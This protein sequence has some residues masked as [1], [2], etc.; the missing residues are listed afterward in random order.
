MLKQ[1]VRTSLSD[2]IKTTM[3][4]QFVIPVYQR[5]YTWSPE[6]ETARYMNDIEGLLKNQNTNRFL[7][8]IIYMESE[9]SAMFRQLQIVDGQQR[10]TTSF[11]FLLALKKYAEEQKDINTAGM[12]GDY[13]LYNRH[14]QGQASLR[15]KPAVSADDV[16][17][18]LVYGNEKDLTPKEKETSVYRNYIY[19]YKRIVSFAKNHTLLE[20]LDTLSRMDILEFPLSATDNAQQIFESINSAGAPLTSADLIRNYVL[21]NHPDAEQERLYRMYWQPMEEMYPESRKLEEFF[22][23]YLAARTYDLLN[24][25]DVY[26]GFKKYWNSNSNSDENKL[27][28]VNRY[29]RYYHDIY[30]GPCSDAEVEKALSDFRLS[31]SRLPAPFFM[32][33]MHLRDE[34]EITSEEL[35]SLIRL[36]DSYLMRRALSGNDSSS[37]SRYFPTLLRSVLTSWYKN[38]KD[39]TGITRLYLITYN[40][41]R[42]L[43][44]PTD[45]QLKTQLR[46]INAYSLTCIR[47]VLERIEH[48]HAT[49]R[50]D[51]SDLNIEHIMPQHPDTWW[52]KHSGAKD[53]DEYTAYAN[54]IGNLTLCAE[55]DNTRMGNEDFAYKKKVLSQT[56]HIRMNTEILKKKTWNIHEILKRCDEMADE[57]IQ[58]YPYYGNEEAENE[59]IEEETSGEE[60]YTLNSPTVSARA[61]VHSEKDTEVLAGSTMKE[62]GN[63]EMKKM[64]DL[65]RQM[66]EQGYFHEIEGGRVQF[67]QSRHFDSL[68]TAAQFLMHRGGENLSRWKKEGLSDNWSTEKKKTD[69]ENKKETEKKTKPEEKNSEIKR[70]SRRKTQKTDQKK[71]SSTMKNPDQKTKKNRKRNVSSGKSETQRN[72]ENKKKNTKQRKTSENKKQSSVSK[73]TNEKKNSGRSSSRKSSGNR[74]NRNPMG[75]VP[76]KNND[77][78][79]QTT[80][81][82]NVIR[83]AGMGMSRPVEKEIP[84]KQ[85]GNGKKKTSP[86]KKTKRSSGSSQKRT[87]AKREKK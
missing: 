27:Q 35:I 62:Y 26:E 75:I 16:F 41:G 44:M 17:A 76:Q 15:L 45:I 58:I 69:M 13:Y 31:G 70:H 80:S 67:T 12:I 85:A 36:I 59:S 72:S 71:S 4:S 55:Y 38:K 33:M 87:S 30:T 73:K 32:E 23:C 79:V 25:R 68:N 37:L 63:R 81:N 7:G 24:R 61:I 65:Y 56:L 11:I 14:S 3:G 40:R 39:I 46:E 21:M 64:K 43:A 57:I 18:R 51:T 9:V 83:F 78:A 74:R 42:S 47:T 2:F 48:H 1:P 53:S 86:R 29:C 28:E 52:R 84:K 20:I 22:R 6:K 50:V 82:P 10:L 34:E 5:I 60:V 8:I 66:D 19:I 77:V 54:L 49:A